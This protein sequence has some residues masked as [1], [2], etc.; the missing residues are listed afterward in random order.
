MKTRTWA[1]VCAALLIS[2][3]NVASREDARWVH[4]FEK[5]VLTSEYY[6][7]G[8]NYGDLDRDGVMD[9]VSGPYWYKGP[10]YGRKYEIY[11]AVA[12]DRSKYADNFFS[13][14]LD[15]DRDGRNDVLVR[16]GWF[17][18]PASLSGDPIWTRHE[19]LFAEAGGAQMYAYDVDGDGDADVITSLDAHGYGL[20]WYEQVRED[21]RITFRQHRIM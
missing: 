15:F 7:E 3:A 10:D 2:R 17:E 13:F 6:S 8:A 11:P 14:V 9:I 5:K 21:G 4:S 12:Q 19:F 20:A 16:D 18:Q 1:L